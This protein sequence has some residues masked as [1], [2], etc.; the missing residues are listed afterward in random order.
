MKKEKRKTIT[1]PIIDSEEFYAKVMTDF[2]QKMHFE[3][4]N[5]HLP[6]F[7]DLCKKLE[8]ELI[9]LE[10]LDKSTIPKIAE[11]KIINPIDNHFDS[12]SYVSEKGTDINTFI[13]TIIK[14]DIVRY[15]LYE[16]SYIAIYSLLEVFFYDICHFIINKEQKSENS[17]VKRS[18][19]KR[20]DDCIDFL[21][22]NY[23][24]D[25]KNI[26]KSI[27]KPFD[28]MRIK[29]NCIVHNWGIINAFNYKK[30]KYTEDKIGAKVIVD[31]IECCQSQV[32]ILKIGRLVEFRLIEILGYDYWNE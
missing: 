15:H 13:E 26:L 25:S 27:K 12:H 22:E 24:F 19:L 32:F 10:T 31:L 11:N 29:R 1:Y 18:N 8:L 20:I 23:D 7:I 16:N 9:V 2:F 21:D 28:T 4:E 3:N 14:S 5:K 30:M 6:I 17:I